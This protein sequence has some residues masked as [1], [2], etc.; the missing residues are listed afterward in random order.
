MQVAATV[1]FLGSAQE[2]PWGQQK[3]IPP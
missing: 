3:K 2:Y 1:P